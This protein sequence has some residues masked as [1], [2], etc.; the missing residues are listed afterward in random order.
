MNH[1][2]SSF[3]YVSSHDLQEP[4]RK[5]QTFGKRIIESEEANLSEAGKDYFARMMNAARRMQLLI[6]DLLSYS[7]VNN[8]AKTFELTDLNNLLL[9]VESDLTI[10]E[11]VITIQSAL[12]KINVIPFQMRQLFANLLSNAIK[13]ARKDVPLQIFINSETVSGGNVQLMGIDVNSS[14]I[15]ISIADNGIGFESKYTDRIF[16]VFQRLH[17]KSEYSGT[18]IG[19]AICKRVVENHRGVITATAEPDKG[20]VFHVYLNANM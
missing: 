11:D 12:P 13:F 8:T 17:G 5:I 6:E 2:L 14:Y 4:L 10:H 1:E 15:H 3:A 16:E 20:S 18:G 19:L 9:G 7:R